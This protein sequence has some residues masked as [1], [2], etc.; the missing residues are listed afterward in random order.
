MWEKDLKSNDRCTYN[1][2]PNAYTKIQIDQ[3]LLY[4]IK[5]YK[6]L[7]KELHT[8]MKQLYSV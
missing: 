1:D 8:L 5:V 2:L 6:G 7:N 3:P 4:W